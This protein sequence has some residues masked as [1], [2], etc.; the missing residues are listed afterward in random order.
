MLTLLWLFAVLV[1]LLTLA[2]VNA[3]GAIGD[4]WITTI[5]LRYAPAARIVDERDGIR[6]YFPGPAD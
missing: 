5:V 6:V 3:S 4:V 2:Y 1:G